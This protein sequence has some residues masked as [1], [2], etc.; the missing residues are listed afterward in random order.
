[1]PVLSS[2]YFLPGS[3][4]RSKWSKT[5]RQNQCMH[6]SDL[7]RIIVRYQERWSDYPVF[8]FGFALANWGPPLF[9]ALEAR[10]QTSCTVRVSN[11]QGRTCV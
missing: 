9:S 5:E 6:E 2:V 4:V 3:I 1:M 10:L 11:L 8:A 7:P